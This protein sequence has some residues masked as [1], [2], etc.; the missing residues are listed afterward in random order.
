MT[1]ALACIGSGAYLA[2]LLV[3]V[4]L[5]AHSASRKRAARFRGV[6]E[7]VSPGFK[8]APTVQLNRVLE[9]RVKL[10]N[11]YKCLWA[12]GTYWLAYVYYRNSDFFSALQFQDGPI[13]G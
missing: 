10:D 1:P 6:I 12:G 4:C 2:V 11:Y 9:A 13:R 5:I 3:L 7:M 8:S